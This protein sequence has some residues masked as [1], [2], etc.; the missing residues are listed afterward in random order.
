MGDMSQPWDFFQQSLHPSQKSMA[1]RGE[2][3]LPSPTDLGW[4]EV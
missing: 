4:P 2:R 3:R 1:G